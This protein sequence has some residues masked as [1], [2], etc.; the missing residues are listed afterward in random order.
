MAGHSFR[1][2]DLP[3]A[4]TLTGPAIAA[5]PVS[6]IQNNIVPLI[7]SSLSFAFR[8]NTGCSIFVIQGIVGAPSGSDTFRNKYA[9]V[10]VKSTLPTRA[11]VFAVSSSARV[12]P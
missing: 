6:G 3:V 2:N 12:F 5:A 10:A 9:G 4:R 11:P 8:P 7:S 1:L